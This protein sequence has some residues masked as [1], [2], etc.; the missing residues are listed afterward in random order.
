MLQSPTSINKEGGARMR[1]KHQFYSALPQSQDPHAVAIWITASGWKSLHSS[2]CRDLASL[3][4]L[5]WT[6]V[7]I[8]GSGVV[9]LIQSLIWF[10]FNKCQCQG[11]IHMWERRHGVLPQVLWRSIVSCIHFLL[12]FPKK[13]DPS[14]GSLTISTSNFSIIALDLLLPRNLNTHDETSSLSPNNLLSK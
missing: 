3:S 8:D 14:T 11:H 10:S 9:W 1:G 2:C 12:C 13:S 6:V 5:T 7:T 4:W